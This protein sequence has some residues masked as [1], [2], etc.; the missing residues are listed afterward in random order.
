MAA[1]AGADLI[2]KAQQQVQEERQTQ[3]KGHRIGRQET[4][5]RQNLEPET[6]GESD[7]LYFTFIVFRYCIQI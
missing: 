7:F 3:R 2:G 4:K 6:G 1:Q 5:H